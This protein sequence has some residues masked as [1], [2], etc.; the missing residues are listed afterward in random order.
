M[1]KLMISMLAMAA[2][3]SCTNEIENPDQ[4][5]VNQNE[6][7]PIEFGSSI[8][9]VQTK[10]AKT[11]T[12][13]SNDEHIGIIGFKGETAPSTDY[14]SPFMNNIDFTYATNKFTASDVSAVW[15]RNATHHFYAYYPLATTTETNGY[16]YTA[17]TASA[18]P[19][20]SVT[21]QTGEEGVKQD[22]LWSNLT[23]K[24]FTGA[25]TEFSADKMKLQFAHKLAR[26]A[27]KVVKKDANVPESA[28]KGIS[29]KVDYKDAS[30]NLISGELT[31]GSQITADADKISLSKT[32]TT[33]ETIS[34]D[35]ADNATCGDFS[36]IIIP[37][38][39]ISNLELTINDQKLAVSD[40][41]T[42]KFE[43][44]D[45][46]TV[47]I[48]VNSK[49]VEFSAAITDWTSVNN[50]TGTVE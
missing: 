33:T 17:G 40:L 29:F 19:T 47:T 32:L 43:G 13:F 21:V 41:S 18:A 31:K 30:L 2:M 5:Q 50:G 15:E 16:K 25:S 4:P 26:I 12:A 48:T 22:L 20:V 27:F 7:T 14:S 39:A 34:V 44:G 11:G 8:L 3:V 35:G 38:T 42:L 45:I 28:L 9:A 23:S 10:A 1:K 49:G 46:T 6:P 36:P 24:K 37:G